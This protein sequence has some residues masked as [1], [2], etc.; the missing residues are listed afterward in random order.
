MPA[1][2]PPKYEK[3]VV[4]FLTDLFTGNNP[5]FNPTEQNPIPVEK[6]Y[7][8]IWKRTGWGKTPEQEAKKANGAW[9]N[10]RTAVRH[11]LET[12]DVLIM[13][14]SNKTEGSTGYFRPTRPEHYDKAYV[15]A[16]KLADS[17]RRKAQLI[18][19]LKARNCQEVPA[20]SKDK[21]NNFGDFFD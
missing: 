4:Q 5:N 15:T 7:T 17:Y 8:A 19:E 18:M 21:Q 20:V 1:K 13:T 14:H 6:L 12:T 2:I 10:T 3:V 11:M 9:G 16:D